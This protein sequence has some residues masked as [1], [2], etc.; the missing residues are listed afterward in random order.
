MSFDP[1][2]FVYS[3][4]FRHSVDD[5]GRVA[6]PRGFRRTLP[7]ESNGRYILNIGHDS[8]IEIHPLSEWK[9]FEMAT[10]SQLDRDDDEERQKL[11]AKLS[12]INE[13]AMD[14][15]FRILIPRYL[16]DYAGLKT[17]SPCVFSGMGMYF[18][19]MT[20]TAFDTR[21]QDFLRNYSKYAGKKK[22]QSPGTPA[23]APRSEV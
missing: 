21:M 15:S 11:R 23:P 17:N 22:P 19:L 13:V 16:L 5:K 7:N 1:E 14:R 8:T 12:L 4:H 18:E 2:F 6:I 9:R 10:L 3:G 20:D